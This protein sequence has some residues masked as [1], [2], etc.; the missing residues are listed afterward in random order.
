MKIRGDSK[1]RLKSFR[2]N[3][4]EKTFPSKEKI[5]HLLSKSSST[6]MLRSVEKTSNASFRKKE[7]D[8]LASMDEVFK[9]LNSNN[10]DNS[11]LGIANAYQSPNLI[12]TKKTAK[13]SSLV[14]SS[15]ENDWLT[16]RVTSSKEIGGN[17]NNSNNSN[18][19]KNSKNSKSPPSL[20]CSMAQTKPHNLAILNQSQIKDSFS[21]NTKN[22][23]NKSFNTNQSQISSKS[24]SNKNYIFQNLKSNLTGQTSNQKLV[25]FQNKGLEKPKSNEK[26]NINNKVQPFLPSSYSL[27][28]KKLNSTKTS[29]TSKHSHSSFENKKCTSNLPNKPEK[30][31]SYEKYLIS[32]RLQNSFVSPQVGEILVNETNRSSLFSNSSGNTKKLEKFTKESSLDEK[33]DYFDDFPISHKILKRMPSNSFNSGT[34]LMTGK[35]ASFNNLQDFEKESIDG[36]EELH[37]I[38]VNLN[39]KQKLFVQKIEH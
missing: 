20:N 14:K 7:K 29:T 24:M 17:S 16:N 3:H 15:P 31:K 37:F 35:D 32:Q 2:E 38:H 9:A 4:E 36:P 5:K 8:S 39:K 22:M 23:L 33:S 11:F 30:E 19:N 18:N 21:H 25:N 1:I 10:L 34:N 28:A 6:T 12:Y 27:L 13:P 26:I